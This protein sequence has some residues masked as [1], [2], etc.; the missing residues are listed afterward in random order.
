M[1]LNLILS[2]LTLLFSYATCSKAQKVPE[3]AAVQEAPVEPKRTSIGGMEVSHFHEG[4]S[5]PDSAFTMQVAEAPR[6][7]KVPLDKLPPATA[8]RRA[9]LAT[10]WWHLNMAFQ[11][12]DTTVHHQY[13]HKWL[14]FKEDQ[15]F[16][17]LIKNQI[18]SSGRWGWNEDKNQV[19]LACNDPYLNNTWRVN[20][21]GFVM[22]WIGNTELNVTGIQVRVI[23]SKTPPP[24]N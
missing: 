12:S 8:S 6:M 20:E 18:V 24:A 21:K 23:D 1:K 14:K 13:Q 15:T 5:N 3:T 9:Y 17:I 16:D 10:G 7:V 19:Y 2:M 4:G 11:P 22:V